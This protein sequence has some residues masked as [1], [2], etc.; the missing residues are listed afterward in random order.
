MLYRYA[1]YSVSDG[2]ESV[3]F[4][5]AI[6]VKLFLLVTS[7]YVGKS[8]GKSPASKVTNTYRLYRH[9]LVLFKHIFKCARPLFQPLSIGFV[10]LTCGSRAQ[11]KGQSVVVLLLFRKQTC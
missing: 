7:T 3:L 4:L 5:F 1:V 10:R 9:I 6:K 11:A 8:K 2:I